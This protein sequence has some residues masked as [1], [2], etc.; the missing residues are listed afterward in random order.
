MA[1]MAT[2]ESVHTPMPVSNHLFILKTKRM[3]F[4]FLKF[5]AAGYA[6]PYYGGYAGYVY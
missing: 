2:L 5:S 1:L 4:N 3:F 6:S